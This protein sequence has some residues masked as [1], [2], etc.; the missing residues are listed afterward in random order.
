MATTRN[1]IQRL[2]VALGLFV[3]TIILLA[4]ILGSPPTTAVAH[5]ADVLQVGTPPPVATPPVP[6]P[7]EPPIATPQPGAAAAT[8]SP[9]NSEVEAAPFRPRLFVRKGEL[10]SNAQVDAVKPE[11]PADIRPHQPP[12]GYQAPDLH[13]ILGIQSWSE[14]AHEGFE[15][16]W[17][18]APWQ[19]YD[20]SADGFERFWD[21][22]SYGYQVGSWSAWPADGGADRIDPW[23]TTWYTDNLSSWMEYGPVDLSSMIDVFISYGLYYDTEPS[24]DWIYFCVSAD[25]LNYSCDY[26]SGW[27]GGWTTQARL[28]TSYA[29]YSTVY[30][31]WW[32]YSDF[33]ISDG[34]YGPYIDEISIWGDTAPPPTPTPT[35]SVA[36]QLIQNCGFETGSLTNWGSS[37]TALE[38]ASQGAPGDRIAIEAQP[39]GPAALTQVSV[40]SDTSAEGTY[41]ARLWRYNAGQDF[42]YQNFN[43]AA[44]VGN[45]SVDYWAGV[46]TNETVPGAD[47]FCASLRNA[48][49]TVILVDLGC[50]DGT[51][52]DG[53]WHE[54]GYTLDSG[55]LDAIRNQQVSLVFELYNDAWGVAGD[56]L[57][58]AWIDFARVQATGGSGPAP[59]DPHEP[60]DE[61]AL[62]TTIACSQT[63][64]GIVGDALGTYD[65]DWFRL[66]SVP[67]GQLH[68]DIDARSLVPTPSALDS[69]V[70]LWN[71][72]GQ[73]MLATNDDDGVTYDSYLVYTNTTANAT[74]Y[75]SVESYTGVGSLDSF[76]NV[77]PR[78]NA[79]DAP[80][81]G[82]TEDLPD[83]AKAWTIMLYLNAE[84]P[85]FAGLLTQYRTDIE[86]FIGGKSAFLDVV[87]LY[88][89]PGIGGTTR[90]L[91]QPGGA[92]SD[93]VNRWNLPEANM[94][95]PATLANFVSWAM[96]Q[97]PAHN[98]YLA[99]DDHG[100]GAYGISFDASSLNDPLTPPE[101]YSALK[102]ATRNGRRKIDLFDYE[103]CL[104]GLAENAYDVRNWVDYVL[105]FQQISWGIN[106]YPAYFSDLAAGDAPVAVG[107]RIV[108]RYYAGATAAGYPHTISLIDANKMAAVNVAAS[109][110]GNALSATHN[111]TAVLNARSG[112]QAF[113]ADSDAT[114]PQ[115]ADYID[116]WHLA[117]RAKNLKP[118]EASALKTA[119]QN[120][121]VAERHASG[122]VDGYIWDH[123]QAHGLSIYF[124]AAK[125]SPAFNS[126]IAPAIYQMSQD[127]TW[128]EFLKW[129]MASSNR[130]GM[131]GTRA[132][133]KLNGGTTFVYRYVYLPLLRK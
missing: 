102:D 57:T 47:Y 72:A 101:L 5:R 58:W 78:C 132:T 35:C 128:D 94:G 11:R 109:N 10:P 36:G 77:Q 96:D 7:L 44:D 20:F 13:G 86:A 65:I 82:G 120:A 116:L 22:T 111:V 100:D 73:T 125:T 87:I 83:W 124:P 34:Y 81:E 9:P 129:V 84:D 39:G 75:V 67:A 4:A 115:R 106:T 105:F 14:L 64:S 23:V 79:A 71:S 122:G 133:F 21:D 29:G 2:A 24:F 121:V 99:I 131:S 40:V 107:R 130:R 31:A 126:Y 3:L 25:G 26:W 69:V 66:N 28:L 15:G 103:A 59:A 93:N 98:Y 80:P 18:A 89:G 60:N 6:P 27:S 63:L 74:F 56:G 97:Y 46:T 19:V 43:V 123:T 114:N 30:F 32:F 104:M 17:P 108:D 45:V 51:A 38:A 88:D 118:A 61:P 48:S 110:F 68:V 95:D 90:Y 16:V 37:S 42:L 91:V 54:T 85:D 8:A 117:E 52:T 62:A 127:G 49:R 92:Y 50:M 53:Y 55:Q 119:V 1:P 12:S 70:K 76:Y 33:S 41:S 112:A 113:A